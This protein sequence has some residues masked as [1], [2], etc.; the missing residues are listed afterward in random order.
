MERRENIQQRVDD[1]LLGRRPAANP[2]DS[3][4]ELRDALNDTRRAMDAVDAAEDEA[5]KARLQKLEQ[6]YSSGAATSVNTTATVRTLGPRPAWRRFAPALAAGLALLV[7]LALWLWPAA[8]VGH[9]E[10]FAAHFQPYENLAVDLTRTDD[11]SPAERA[12]TAYEAGEY[13]RA[14]KLMQ[15]LDDRPA[16]RFYRAQALLASGNHTAAIPL[17]NDLMEASDF[18]LRNQARWYYALAKLKAGRPA[19]ARTTLSEIAETP[20][21]PFRAE[22]RELLA[23]LP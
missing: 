1:E 9:E 19:A 22:A 15:E 17:L 11:P 14:A 4:P 8:A 10:L 12:F 23:R 2:K 13:E 16:Y 21:H 3:D 18:P 7:A 6:K 20:D 5:L